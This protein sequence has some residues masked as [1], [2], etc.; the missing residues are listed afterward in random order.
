MNPHY[1]LLLPSKDDPGKLLEQGPGRFKGCCS[2][3]VDRGWHAPHGYLRV[4]IEGHALLIVHE[5]ITVLPG[6]DVAA[7]ALLRFL[8]VEPGSARAATLWQGV[9]TGHWPSWIWVVV[10]YTPQAG[11]NRNPPLLLA[12]MCSAAGLGT[13]IALDK[14][15]VV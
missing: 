3:V 6:R 9:W 14:N 13:V 7:Y 2:I 5:G 8:S 1:V 4:G 10:N 15:G 12:R 11:D